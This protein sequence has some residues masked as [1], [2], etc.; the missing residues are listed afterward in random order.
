[1]TVPLHPNVLPLAGLIGTWRGEGAGTYPTITPFRYGEEISFRSSGKPFL[2]YEQRTWALD[3]GRPLHAEAG[4]WRPQPDGSVEVVMAHPTGIVEVLEGRLEGGRIDLTST[5][6]ATTS[7]A[8]KVTA[9]G[10]RAPRRRAR[11]HPVDG[12]GRP[13]VA[14]PPQRRAAPHRAGL[15]RQ[16]GRRAV[17]GA[18]VALPLGPLGAA[19]RAPGG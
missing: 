13:A 11:L 7:T 2:A 5:T 3:D 18:G 8:V 12:G 15:R 4:Y 17:S 16:G 14:A 6:V 10:L 9:L 19:E 1:V